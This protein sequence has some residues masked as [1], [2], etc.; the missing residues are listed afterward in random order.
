MQESRK[1]KQKET[2]KSQKT[3]EMQDT[4][5][6]GLTRE[7]E[8]QQL[9][10]IIDMAQE[11]LERTRGYIGDLSEELHDLLETY[12]TKDK[13]ALALWHNTESQ[14]QETRR[15]LMRCERARKKPYFGRIDFRDS[16]L[17][18]DE[19]YY[20]G[21]VGISD[22][23]SE[24]VVIDWRAPVA[25]VYYEN[26]MGPCKYMVRN[27]GVHEID[28]KRKR[29][30]EIADDKLVDFFDS[31]VV[32]N[33]ELLTKYLAKSK[34]AVLGEIIATIQKEQNAIIRKS[35]KTNLIVQGVAGSGKTTVA[36]HRI[37]YILYNYEEFR[38]ED[39]YIIGSNR[40]L[41]NYIT[42]VLPDLDV[43]GISQMTME[44]LFVRLMYEDWDDKKYRIIS[45]DRKDAAAR[46]KGSYSWFHDLE[47]FCDEYERR[48]I[49]CEDAYLVKD[50][51]N[52]TTDAKK[53]DIGDERKQQKGVLLMKHARIISYLENNPGYSMQEKIDMLN[54]ILH[55]RM[56]NEM[57][58]K[59]VTYTLIEKKQLQRKYQFYFGKD[60]W[61]GSIHEVYEEFL[62][63]QQR[64][65]KEVR[66]ITKT[67]ATSKVRQYDV[68]D[69]AAL[70]F[71]Y[72]RIKENDR[73]REATHVIIDE[74]Q[75]FGMMAYGVLKYCLKDCTYTIMGDVSQNIHF[76]YGLDD[77]EELKALMLT[78][79]FDSFD[80]LKKSYRNT[81][82]ISD[83]ATEIL[84][85]GDF[86]IYP[87]EPIIRHG[88]AVKVQT[89]ADE[90]GM[91]GWAADTIKTWQKDGHDTIAVVCRDEAEADEIREKLGTKITL[92]DSN[93]ETAEFG[94]GV[95]VL[96]VEYTKGLEFDAVLIYHP[97]AEKYPE[98]DQ[99][100]KLL[101]VAATRALHEL[102]VVHL[103]DLTELI[104][105]PV[106][107]E[108]RM[109]S[110]EQDERPKVQLYVKVE[111]TDRE[112]ALQDARD[113]AKEMER[114]KYMGPKRIVVQQKTASAGIQTE[115]DNG[116]NNKAETNKVEIN[117][118]EINKV[119]NNKAADR[120][121]KVSGSIEASTGSNRKKTKVLPVKAQIKDE[122]EEAAYINP[123]PCAFGSGPS[124]NS[125]LRPKGHGRIDASI[126]WVKKTK[127]YIDL[128]SNYGV[129]RITPIAEEVV[130]VQFKKGQLSDFET[131]Y[132]NKVP[133]ENISGRWSARE[134][135]N[136]V[137]ITVGK[138]VIRL[139]KKTGALQ[140][141]DVQGKL[142][143]AEKQTLPRQIESGA[144]MAGPR[145]MVPSETWNYFEWSKNEKLYAKGVLK[146]SFERM[147]QKA[148]YISFGGKKM[149]MPLLVS[150]YGYGI[151]V[152]AESTVLCCDIAM[153]GPYLYT[154]GEQIDY[155][156]LCGGS[157]EKNVE[158]YSQ[159]F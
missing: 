152:S 130:R 89:F 114:R 53:T 24:P 136:L 73:I 129:L 106:S 18:K 61:K 62:E 29:T 43:Y 151:G 101:Y 35:P 94:N 128:A 70:A 5:L 98:E 50:E 14:L 95:M 10:A 108:K 97:S 143:L 148:Q 74:A 159:L 133:D 153:Y 149:R 40:I 8:E 121:T 60:E 72:R 156:Y 75:D 116:E 158:I 119:A 86:P 140:F 67:K 80:L 55:S 79:E 111:F 31:D 68:Y 36:M 13:E 82:E 90:K 49:P 99:F 20:V 44:Q 122:Q 118:S 123:S 107:E 120:I 145:G 33:D 63:A 115:R 51:E 132:W 25:S 3:D 154:E 78:G 32:A 155:Y 88:N 144:G 52:E 83:F 45:L 124:D 117:K 39:F 76:G 26:A 65:G 28:L 19:S 147:N 34:K 59:Y 157:R 1:S 81:V 141:F 7:A 142:I 15:D 135:K 54:E 102:A 91:V 112:L 4:R 138:I 146:D 137:Q 27:V 9:S 41:L 125:M 100:V 71:I 87:V 30:Y 77:W 110:L 48:V 37:S 12:G 42:G 46:K 66:S 131:G 126:R 84:R 23:K 104:G 64:D 38:P 47:K 134:S 127:K 150:E 58:G 85:H 56:E 6:Y 22:D 109:R 2:S 92:T 57:S 139:E 16:K 11:N 113:G 105:K 96:P 21:R 69:L 17:L 103:G 93:L